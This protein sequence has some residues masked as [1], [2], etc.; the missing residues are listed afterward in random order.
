[1]GSLF[2]ELGL[3]QICL[4]Q[5]G[6]LVFT[7]TVRYLIL[8]QDIC[9]VGSC[10]TFLWRFKL[11]SIEVFPLRLFNVNT[12]YWVIN[13]CEQLIVCCV[14]KCNYITTLYIVCLCQQRTSMTGVGESATRPFLDW[15]RSAVPV[16]M[17]N[18]WKE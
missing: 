18:P 9:M 14:D 12:V 6:F 10:F 8:S 15:S 4:H 7:Y 3:V 17:T 5:Q 2:P 1:M 13:S 11:I 16:K